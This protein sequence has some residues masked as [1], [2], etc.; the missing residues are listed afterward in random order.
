[1]GRREEKGEEEV[2]EVRLGLNEGSMEER[3][4]EG[5]ECVEWRKTE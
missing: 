1:M 4:Q 2:R 5:A 3:E